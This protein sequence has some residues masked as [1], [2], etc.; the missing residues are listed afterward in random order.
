ML[1]LWKN[2]IWEEA[3][4]QTDLFANCLKVHVPIEIIEDMTRPPY[5]G[6]YVHTNMYVLV[7]GTIALIAV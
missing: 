6:I 1:I 5:K 3:G 4:P 2:F 7:K